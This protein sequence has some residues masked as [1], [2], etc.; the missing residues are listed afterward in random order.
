M[1]QALYTR[2]N[3]AGPPDR[4]TNTPMVEARRPL[5]LPRRFPRLHLLGPGPAVIVVIEE[6]PPS[7]SYA[8]P[9]R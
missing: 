7:S 9:L 4:C 8:G 2:R 5:R 6:I 1:M 3:R